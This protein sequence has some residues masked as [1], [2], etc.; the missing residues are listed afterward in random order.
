MLRYIGNGNWAPGVP[1]RDLTTDE[2]KRYGG[3]AYLL[4]LGLYEAVRRP[5]TKMVRAKV[6]DKMERVKVEDKRKE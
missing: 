1:A 5:R 2:V 3:R 6:E 4:S